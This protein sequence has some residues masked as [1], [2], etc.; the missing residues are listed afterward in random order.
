M[1]LILSGRELDKAFE[2]YLK[3]ILKRDLSLYDI[4]T[5]ITVTRTA[6]TGN[7]VTITLTEKTLKEP[8]VSHEPTPKST[9]SFNSPPILDEE[10]VSEDDVAVPFK[11]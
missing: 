10:E 7:T 5:N 6:N 11:L 8:E 9:D 4:T 1:E 3:G 2:E